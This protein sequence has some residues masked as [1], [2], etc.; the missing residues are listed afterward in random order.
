MINTELSG[1]FN[2]LLVG[3]E[4]LVKNNRFTESQ[5]VN[6]ALSEFKRQAD[7][8]ALFIEEFTYVTSQTHKMPLSDLY[9]QYKGFCQDDGYKHLGKNKFSAKL[10]SKGFE[11]TRLNDGSK[12]FFIEQKKV[13]V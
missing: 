5:K 12:G 8:V 9:S 1:V 7:N 3:L 10:E 2:W 11:S 4:R 6:H 13:S